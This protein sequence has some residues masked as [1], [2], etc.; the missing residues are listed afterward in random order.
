[1]SASSEQV[2]STTPASKGAWPEL[3]LVTGMSSAG[4]STAA[5]VLEDLGWYVVDNL[6]PQMLNELLDLAAR[7]GS[8]GSGGAP[9]AG[10]AAV[11]DVRSRSFF[12]ALQDALFE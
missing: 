4:R 2:T 12:Q 1:M 5:N 3:V 7:G 10:I 8:A 9:T 11:V 6:P